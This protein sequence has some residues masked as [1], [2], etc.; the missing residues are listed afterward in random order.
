MQVSSGT[1][2]MHV[3]SD[4][5]NVPNPES[6]DNS[7]CRI[8]IRNELNMVKISFFSLD[9]MQFRSQLFSNIIMMKKQ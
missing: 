3:P 4:F 1:T 5:S 8:K 9:K 7:G 6:S 2:Y